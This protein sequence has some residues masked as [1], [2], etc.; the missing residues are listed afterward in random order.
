MD[1]SCICEK[2]VKVSQYTNLD[3]IINGIWPLA[4]FLSVVF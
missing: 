2:V 3:V 4:I 1:N